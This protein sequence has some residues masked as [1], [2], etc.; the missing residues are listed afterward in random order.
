MSLV[1]PNSSGWAA[2]DMTV[3]GLA[4]VNP[5]NVYSSNNVYA[6]I[7]YSPDVYLPYTTSY[8]LK[9]T[10]FNFNIPVNSTILGIVAKIEKKKYTTVINHDVID[11]SVKLCKAGIVGGN[12]KAKAG[13]WPS[14]NGIYQYG[15][16]SDL[17]GLSL[18][19]ADIMN[20]GFGIAISA[21]IGDI[22]YVGGVYGNTVYGYID[23]INLTVYFQAHIPYQII[24]IHD[25]I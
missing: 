1:G 14:S 21:S 8:Y 3:G 17:W 22:Y 10:N 4:W 19:A 13:F 7:S 16:A 9:A 12:N 20:S 11:Y 24:Q 23:H 5:A 15:G 6:S 25:E 2:N 18:T